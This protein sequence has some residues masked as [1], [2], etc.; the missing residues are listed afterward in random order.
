MNKLSI[1]PVFVFLLLYIFPLG[2]RPLVIPDESR[3][4]EISREMVE[5]ADFVVPRLNG[6]RYF[7]KPVMGYWLNAA[8]LI[9]FGENNFSVRF[10]SACSAG[11]SALVLFFLARRFFGDYFGGILSSM[12]FLTCFEVFAVGVFSVLDS[13]FSF[14][15]TAAITCFYY[16]GSGTN[17]NIALQ[18]NLFI[19]S[20]GV[21]IGFAFLTKG[22]L[23]VVLPVIIIAPFLIWEKRWKD[24]FTAPWIPLAAA[25]LVV[26]PWAVMIHLKEPD[27]WNYFFWEEHIRRFSADNAQHKA[28]FFYYLLYFPA[29]A[30]PWT[31]FAPNILHGLRKIRITE[32]PLF[33]FAICWFVF[34]FLFFSM[35]K[36]KLLTYILPCFVP[37]ALLATGGLLNCFGNESGKVPGVLLYKG[38]KKSAF[39]AAG[40]FGLLFVV[41]A[42]MQTTN[43]FPFRPFTQLSKSWLGLS[44]CFITVIFY[45]GAA[46]IPKGRKQM[47]FIATA[48][49][50]FM[51][52]AHFLFPDAV[53]N[54]KSP[55]CFLMK[56]SAKI[57]PDTIIVSDF[58]PLKAVCWYYKR[59]DV[60][61][62]GSTGELTYG[63]QYPD[64]SHRWLGLDEINELIN[65]RS[66]KLVIVARTRSYKKWKPELPSPVFADENGE[67]VF[68]MF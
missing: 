44:V 22:F 25:V 11:L 36:G 4:A 60:F 8:S 21:F 43:I 40:F 18:K 63:I 35:S 34:P 33:K 27:F 37:F 15:I 28:P 14:F 48:P 66:G 32:D 57:H 24:L 41:L 1:L 53:I 49:L 3:Y 26:L 5:T 2:V 31:F 52:A 67:F 30:V 64:S 65:E 58:S 39:T 10:A 38:L 16:A 46:Y 9:A 55:G 68:A 29:A 12:I 56:H 7:E 20:C 61:L 42:I 51:F 6:L 59:S 17:K 50:I 13:M 23:A 19:T 54:K 47:V 45:L 62:T